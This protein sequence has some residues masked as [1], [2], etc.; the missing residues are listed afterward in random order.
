MSDIYKYISSNS[1]FK[2]NIY[3]NKKIYN[4]CK[5]SKHLN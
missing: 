3:I 1:I 2:F 4:I 5:R